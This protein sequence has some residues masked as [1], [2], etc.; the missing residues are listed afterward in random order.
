MIYFH[1][2]T[3]KKN[4][5]KEPDSRVHLQNEALSFVDIDRLF[6]ELA[7]MGLRFHARRFRNWRKLQ[8]VKSTVEK[9]FDIWGIW[10]GGAVIVA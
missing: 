9:M 2:K 5:S 7:R 4:Q 8:N 3:K 10:T 1:L 6:W